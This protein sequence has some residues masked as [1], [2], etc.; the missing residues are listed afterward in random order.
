MKPDEESDMVLREPAAAHSVEP[1]SAVAKPERLKTKTQSKLRGGQSIVTD[2]DEFT[3]GLVR[4]FG[5]AK[6]KAI[7]ENRQ[8]RAHG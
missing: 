7:R 4:A 1:M 3:T 2:M 8:L 5:E 6:D